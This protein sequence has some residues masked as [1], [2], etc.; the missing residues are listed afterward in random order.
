LK[1]FQSS[2]RDPPVD[3]NIIP[4]YTGIFYPYRGQLSILVNRAGEI[5][6][7]LIE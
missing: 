5:L 7:V 6:M 2:D 3:Q 1:K 4:Q